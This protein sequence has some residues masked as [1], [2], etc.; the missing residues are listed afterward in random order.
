MSIDGPFEVYGK[1]SAC[2]VIED[3]SAD[4]LVISAAT[5]VDQLHL[6]SEY[7]HVHCPVMLGFGSLLDTSILPTRWTGGV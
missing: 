3:E 2:L 7:S 5:R 1:F 4:R 6:R